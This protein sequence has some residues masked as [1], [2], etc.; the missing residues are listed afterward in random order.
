MGKFI[1]Y[2]LAVIVTLIVILVAIPFFISLDTY[3]EKISEQAKL[4]TGRD[5]TIAGKISLDLFP[6]PEVKLEKVSF[7]SIKGARSQVLFEAESLMARLEFMPLLKGNVVVSSIELVQPVINLERLK[8]GKASWEIQFPKEEPSKK[9]FSKSTEAKKEGV[10][11]KEKVPLAINNISITKGS[12]NYSDLTNK[13]NIEDFNI[14]ISLKDLYNLP[15]SNPSGSRG[16]VG[17]WSKDK[18]DLSILG[19][20]NTNFA[21]NAKK[22]TAADHQLD[23]FSIESELNE[24]ILKIKDLSGNILGGK[25]N[26]MGSFS[27]K[28]GQPI[29][30]KLELKNAQIRDIAPEMNRIKITSGALDF[31]INIKSRG[32]SQYDYIKNL[33]GSINMIA[34]DGVLSGINLEQITNALNKPRD[35]IVLGKNLSKGVGK[36]ETPFSSLMNDVQIEKGIVSINKCEL[37]SANT[38]ASMEGK[39]NLPAFTMDTLATVNSGIKNIPPIK[40]RLYGPIDN[41][42]HKIDIKAI[43]QHLAKNALTGVVENLKKGKLDP[44]D[45]LKGVIGGG[46]SSSG[47]SSSS[48]NSSGD[49]ANKLLQKGL[50]GLFK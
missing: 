6:M 50:K 3:K 16:S 43:W 10:T 2:T 19:I 37:I 48:G 40:V 24:S 4:H 11:S 21:F 8:N 9:T 5:L 15:I 14:K 17:P 44:K 28:P 42:Q 20:A 12:L 38:A 13:A 49:A 7:S 31:A 36:G 32:Q 29:D 41:M 47:E 18:I 33:Q 30:F 39:V 27:G 34:R 26:G 1:K 35:I 45:L 46:N 22:I 23:N 25:F